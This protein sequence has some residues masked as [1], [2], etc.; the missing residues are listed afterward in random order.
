[1]DQFAH[2]N[3]ANAAN[4]S[5]VSTGKLVLDQKEGAVCS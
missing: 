2:S 3:Q 5:D 1:M 4:F